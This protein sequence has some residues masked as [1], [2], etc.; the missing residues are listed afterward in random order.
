MSLNNIIDGQVSTPQTHF[1]TVHNFTTS[2]GNQ[3]FFKPKDITTNV[4]ANPE[5]SKHL[6]FEQIL[7]LRTENDKVERIVNTKA[8][9]QHPWTTIHLQHLICNRIG[10]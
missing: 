7:P 2:I 8:Y 4:L 9:Q 5:L 1:A 10:M 6:T 3:F